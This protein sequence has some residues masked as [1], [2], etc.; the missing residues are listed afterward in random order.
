[1]PMLPRTAGYILQE[2]T[3]S[4]KRNGWLNFA[5]AGTTAVSLFMLGIAILLVINTNFIASSVESNVQIMAYLES[6]TAGGAIN[7]LQAQIMTIPGVKDAQFISKDEALATLE[8]QFSQDGGLQE[9]LEG[10]NP[11]PDAF[12]VSAVDPRN[13]PEIANILSQMPGVGKVSYGQDVVAK[14]FVITYWL[15]LIGLI[16]VILL[17]LCAIFLIATTTR[18][19]LFAKRRE[20]AIMKLVGA[21][22]WY[23]RWPFLVEGIIL[24]GAGAVAAIGTLFFSYTTLASRIMETLPFLPLMNNGTELLQIFGGLLAAGVGLGIVG[25]LI[26]IHRYLQA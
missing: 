15:R 21:T 2:S 8:Q 20:I 3:R 1:M 4:L 12:K 16:I 17:G 22:D 19:T 13:V 5:A 11:L 7:T 25:S 6:G 23:V 26:S 24:G 18:L 10:S 14:L 9:T